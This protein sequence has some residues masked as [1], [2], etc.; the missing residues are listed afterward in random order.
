MF[1]RYIFYVN[2]VCTIG[3]HLNLDLFVAQNGVGLE[4]CRTAASQNHQFADKQ[5]ERDS[6]DKSDV[7]LCMLNNCFSLHVKYA[8]QEFCMRK[9]KKEER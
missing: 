3:T 1:G 2:C 5:D 9:K 4:V 8:S 6:Y 7:A